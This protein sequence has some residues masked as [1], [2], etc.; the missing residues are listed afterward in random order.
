[1]TM[2]MST[3][4]RSSS[5]KTSA[6]LPTTPTDQARRSRLAASA[7]SMASSRRV[8]NLVE[9]AVL[10]PTVEPM[11][12]DVDDEARAPVEGDRERLRAAHPAAAAGEGERPGQRAGIPLVGD[13][14]EGLVGALDDPLGA[15]VDPRPGGHLAVHRQPEVLQPPELRPGRP[16]ADEVGVGDEHARRPLVGA[17]D[18][19][20]FARLHEHR[21]VLAQRREGADHGVVRRPRPGRAPGA[22]VDDEVVGALGDLGVEVVHEHPQRRLGL[23][24]PGGELGAARCADRTGAVHVR[25]LG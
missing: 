1:V 9:V 19:D 22:A 11:P 7:I 3:P 24:G 2:S 23:P 18:P 16:V 12:V 4:R 13:G 8:G 5:G 14:G 17:H 15:D 6:A 10:D 25:L 20:R 21:L